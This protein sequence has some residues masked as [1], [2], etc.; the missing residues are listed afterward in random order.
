MVKESTLARRRKVFAPSALVTA[1]VHSARGIAVGSVCDRVEAKLAFGPGNERDESQ[2]FVAWMRA[3][4][5][6]RDRADGDSE[7]DDTGEGPR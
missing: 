4:T 7:K 6:Q 2:G 1:K 3:S 5:D